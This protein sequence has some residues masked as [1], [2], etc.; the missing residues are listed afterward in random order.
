MSDPTVNHDQ[1]TGPAGAG[2]VGTKSPNTDGSETPATAANTGRH[3]FCQAPAALVRSRRPGGVLKTY[4]GLPV[5]CNQEVH[6]TTLPD[7]LRELPFLG[8][9][10][11]KPGCTA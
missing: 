3:T 6:G 4:L 1:A 10:M 11:P 5:H 2:G 9:R 7:Y 8:G